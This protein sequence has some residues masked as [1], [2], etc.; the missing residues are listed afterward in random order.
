MIIVAQQRIFVKGK[1]FPKKEFYRKSIA[2]VYFSEEVWYN[3]TV[4]FDHI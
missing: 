1:A 3:V 4:N 2:L